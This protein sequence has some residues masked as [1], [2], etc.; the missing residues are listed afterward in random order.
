MF[1][2][3]VP[4]ILIVCFVASFV[5]YQ[6]NVRRFLVVCLITVCQSVKIYAMVLFLDAFICTSICMIQELTESRLYLI[7]CVCVCMYSISKRNLLKR[8]TAGASC[9]H[10]T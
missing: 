3:A 9:L 8:N 4:N 10:R 5:V 2:T 7:L 1:G 6:V